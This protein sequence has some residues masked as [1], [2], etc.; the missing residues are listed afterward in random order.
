[1][2]IIFLRSLFVGNAPLLNV[3]GIVNHVPLSVI[4]PVTVIETVYPVPHPGMNI[5]ARLV[6]VVSSN[7]NNAPL[8]STAPLASRSLIYISVIK[9]VVAEL[10]LKNPVP[11]SSLVV[12]VEN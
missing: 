4:A 1:M 11:G 10:N 2:P 7:N 3:T 8:L 6:P 12:V 9:F 5:V